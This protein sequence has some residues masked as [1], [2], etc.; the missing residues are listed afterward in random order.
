L[1]SL[2]REHLI[3]YLLHR[4]PEEERAAFEDRWINEPDLHEQLTIV[5]GEL[6]DAYV[7]D[8]LSATDK[9]AIESHLL[10]SRAQQR[11]LEFARALRRA[12]AK[13]KRT[14]RFSVSWAAVAAC[15]LLSLSGAAWL[16]WQNL[17]LQR[18][19]SSLSARPV[20]SSEAI[21]TLLLRPD[22]TRGGSQPKDLRPPGS[23]GMIRLDLE[24]DPGD[25]HRTYTASVLSGDSRVWSEEPIQPE[26]RASRFVA[27]IWIPRL[28][29]KA[30]QYRVELSSGGR[31]VDY[32]YFRVP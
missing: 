20:P 10:G 14:T 23:A 16:A 3:A 32:Y 9:T 2:N 8:D 1:I 5:E 15:L 6:M 13:P 27:P 21:Y 22:T 28:L 11:K 7:R 29:L 24:L 17:A 18:E 31:T 4:M 30:G 12:V 26:S 19:V 25:E